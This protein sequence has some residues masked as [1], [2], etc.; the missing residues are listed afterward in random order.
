MKKKTKP[1]LLDDQ[2]TAAHIV[3]EIL[4]E[5]KEETKPDAPLA[6]LNELAERRI[7]EAGASPAFKDYK[8]EWAPTPF[9]TALCTSVEFEACHGIPGKRILQAGWIVKYDIGVKYGQGC[10][11][12]CITVGVGTIDN[13]KERLMRYALRALYA[14]IDEVKAGTPVSR[15][16]DRIHSYILRNGFNVIRQYGG[17]GIGS[18]IHQKPDILN[19]LDVNRKEEYYLKEGEVICIEPM[20]TRGKALIGIMPDGWTAYCLDGKPVAQYEAMVLVKNDGYE[21]LTNHL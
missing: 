8:P 15:I 5:L 1:T 10:A 18:E 4:L 20:V 17:H 11:D 2:R 7:K 14:G 3:S 9:P 6:L 16:G 13:A 21:I 12:A 19:Y